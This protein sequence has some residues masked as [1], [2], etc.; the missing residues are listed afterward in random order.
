MSP[1][2]GVV[3]GFKRSPLLKMSS[4]EYHAQNVSAHSAYGSSEIGYPC[5]TENPRNIFSPWEISGEGPI[6]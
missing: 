2:T 4:M 1:P 5:S 6:G 3:S